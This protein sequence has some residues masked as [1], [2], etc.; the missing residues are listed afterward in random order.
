MRK[1]ELAEKV[2]KKV[3]CPLFNVIM[4]LGRINTAKYLRALV[5][6]DINKPLVWFVPL[7]LKDKKRYPVLYEKLL[8]FF[9]FCG[10]VGH[11]LEECGDG[12]HAVIRIV[13][14]GNAFFGL[15]NQR[16]AEV[17][18]DVVMDEVGD[19]VKDEVEEL[20]ESKLRR[21]MTWTWV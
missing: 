2:A 9:Y 4:N 20:V 13:G 16:Q 14:G 5:F 3:G 6:I 21:R 19:Q 11:V 8:D 15:S 17:T 1:V 7:I 10:L 12:V 18:V